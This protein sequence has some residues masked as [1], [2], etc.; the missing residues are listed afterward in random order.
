M[1]NTERHEIRLTL[2]EAAEAIGCS[3][4][5]LRNLI[6]L[7]EWHHLAENP[8]AP[9]VHFQRASA[10]GDA[11]VLSPH[12]VMTLCVASALADGGLAGKDSMYAAARFAL[13]GQSVGYWTG[14]SKLPGYPRLP[15]MTFKGGETWL[16][17]ARGAALIAHVTD[18]PV[19]G[20]RAYPTLRQAIEELRLEVLN[21][22]LILPSSRRHIS[23]TALKLDGI[24]EWLEGRINAVLASKRPRNTRLRGPE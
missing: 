24:T 16:L 22:D 21:D 2:P 12:S 8:D 19:V 5:R 10:A 4:K 20:Y 23:V 7:P 14:D 9:D 17:S 3:P 13:W 1:T 15:S 18:R 6:D 11:V